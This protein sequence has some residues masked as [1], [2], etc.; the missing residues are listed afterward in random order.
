MYPKESFGNTPQQDAMTQYKSRSE[1]TGRLVSRITVSS[2]KK[3]D[4]FVLQ[5][6]DETI[7]RTD[8]LEVCLLVVAGICCHCRVASGPCELV[9]SHP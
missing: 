2:V 9:L 4:E 3:K 1:T 6:L 8:V 7:T 5:L